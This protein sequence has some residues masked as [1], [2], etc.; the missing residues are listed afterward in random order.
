MYAVEQSDAAEMIEEAQSL[1]EEED[2]AIVAGSKM[3]H[4]KTADSESSETRR[5]AEQE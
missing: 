5:I 2:I 4:R 3:D 1:E